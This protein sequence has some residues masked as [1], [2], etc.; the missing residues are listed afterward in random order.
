LNFSSIL[1]KEIK[2]IQGF[3]KE[4]ILSIKEN[5]SKLTKET[6][7][8]GKNSLREYL[9]ELF[10]FEQLELIYCHL[11]E[12]EVFVREFLI[13][14]SKSSNT[15]GY[16]YSF[17]KLNI[18]EDLEHLSNNLVSFKINFRNVLRFLKTNELIEEKVKFTENS[19]EFLERIERILGEKDIQT[20]FI[21]EKY[22]WIWLKINEIKDFNVQIIRDFD[23]LTNWVFYKEL[24]EFLTKNGGKLSK[25][26]K[27]KKKK[28]AELANK[29]FR[30]I[31]DFLKSR[32]FQDERL[33]A[34]LL[35]LLQ[36][37]HFIE[38]ILSEL[39]IMPSVSKKKVNISNQI[40]TF[41]EPHIKEQIIK[42]G[43]VVLKVLT[44]NSKAEFKKKLKKLS[45]DINDLMNPEISAI[46]LLSHFSSTCFE[47]LEEEYQILIEEPN[48]LKNY[49]DIIQQYTNDLD[50]LHT[51]LENIKENLLII[52]SLLRP[53]ETILSSLKKTIFNLEEEILRK[54][55]DFSNYVK[56]IKN[57]KL[58]AEI[59][60]FIE[61]KIQEINEFTTVFQENIFSVINK[62]FPEL[63]K[64]RELLTNQAK[65]IKKIKTEIHD[66][67]QQYKSEDI[68]LF[69]IIKRWEQNFSSKKTQQGFLL[70]M[71]ITKLLKDFKEFMEEE[72]SIFNELMEI[73]GEDKISGEEVLP[74]NYTMNE[75]LERFTDDEL[76]D[77]LVEIQ[78]KINDLNKKMLLYQQEH[79]KIEKILTK[80][81]KIKEGILKTGVKCGVCREEINF[82][83]DKIIKCPFCEAVYHYLCVAFW[84]SKYN[85]CP[86]CQNKFLDPTSNLF[87][88]S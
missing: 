74:L 79:D 45:Q 50:N 14:A 68:D 71:F 13:K 59:K 80:R 83:R 63:Q 70:S 69:P 88:P 57:E 84:L 51:F 61:K 73:R 82:A 1:T 60:E 31:I 39:D 58:R 36:E 33:I 52:E 87:E 86:T 40:L 65:R 16:H 56:S 25:K 22:S 19:L 8:E 41:I 47:L 23:M 76:R 15:N 28:K 48:E 67:L 37:N 54:K 42:E 26:G 38:F 10:P 30:Q 27:K 12:L 49:E 32:G 35:F 77:R 72:S 55:E 5:L 24:H 6:T 46:E 11:S 64:I 4:Q 7:E 9:I 62:E 43:Q 18:K 2:E 34:D 81:V 20:G 75:L 44:N 85:S 53:H 66:L 3:T 29:S 78:A 17:L 21:Q